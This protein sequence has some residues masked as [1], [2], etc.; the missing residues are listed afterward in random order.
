MLELHAGNS[1]NP[2]S[3]KNDIDQKY[4]TDYHMDAYKCACKLIAEGKTYDLVDLDPYGSPYELIDLSLRLATKGLMVTFGELGHRRFNRVD[5]VKP[6]YG[7]ATPAELTIEN[8]IAYIEARARL[9]KKVVYTFKKKTWTNIGRAWLIIQ[10]NSKN[11][12]AR[13]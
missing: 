7:I 4:D 1:K 2:I 9:N 10:E 13:K 5:F 12:K 3:T 6:R 11:D 8:L